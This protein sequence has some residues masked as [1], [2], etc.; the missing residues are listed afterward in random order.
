MVA[1]TRST[2]SRTSARDRRSQQRERN[3]QK[4]AEE[5]LLQ[6]MQK[7]RFENEF[8]NSLDT[9]RGDRA[10][11]HE[12]SKLKRRHRNY[13]NAKNA[14]KVLKQ[15]SSSATEAEAA[16]SAQQRATRRQIFDDAHKLWCLLTESVTEF[17]DECRR[18]LFDLANIL[19]AM[20]DKARFRIQ[21]Y[22]F[23]LPTE[24]Q[25]LS[26]NHD[27]NGGVGGEDV[28]DDDNNGGVGGEDAE[29]DD[30]EDDDDIDD[31]LQTGGKQILCIFHILKR[32]A[33]GDSRDSR[34]IKNFAVQ[35]WM[36]RY[37]RDIE[38]GAEVTKEYMRG[39]K[40]DDAFSRDR[41]R[42][43]ENI[44][45]KGEKILSQMYEFVR[46]QNRE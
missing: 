8:Y 40:N 30:V 16:A 1:T 9:E 45:Y 21:H 25:V 15:L 4:H 19:G 36:F 42:L 28:E 43:L 44:T 14:S 2:L 33:A 11:E 38:L 5:A 23:S 41:L 26:A 13:E 12:I 24:K 34:E 32:F 6:P 31:L 46:G 22:N 7:T 20:D 29:D 10:V 37:W 17:D 18:W 35:Y 3:K 39:E 27:N